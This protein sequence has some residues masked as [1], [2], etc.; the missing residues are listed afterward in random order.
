MEI[1]VNLFLL[2]FVAV[3]FTVYNGNINL[4][5]VVKLVYEFPAT[6]EPARL[7]QNFKSSNLPSYFMLGKYIEM[8]KL[9]KNLAL[10]RY[11][12]ILG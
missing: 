4:F 5:A 12:S 9:C 2:R 8:H 6:G 3:D 10:I 7:V 1:V 11:L